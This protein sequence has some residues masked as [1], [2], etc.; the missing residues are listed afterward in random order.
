MKHTNKVVEIT[1]L[2]WIMKILA[3]TLGDLLIKPL[4]KGGL[5]LETIPATIVSSLLLFL[6][7]LYAGWKHSKRK[8]NIVF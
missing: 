7:M 4:E 6:L 2:F 5:N 8:N 1:L 3:T